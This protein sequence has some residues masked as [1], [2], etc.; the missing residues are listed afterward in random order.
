MITAIKNSNYLVFGILLAGSI[1]ACTSQYDKK[2]EIKITAKEQNVIPDV[3]TIIYAS[4]DYPLSLPGELA[5]Y[6]EVELH[7]KINGFLEKI[8]VQRGDL[9]QKGQ[10]LAELVAPEVDQQYLSDQSVQAEKES[11]YLFAKQAYERL[12]EASKTEGAVAQIELDRANSYMMS[13]KSA[14]ESSQAGTEQSS[15]LKKYLKITA[16][17]EGIITQRN[18]SLG[19]LV[20]PGYKASIF[21]IAQAD[22]LRLTVAIPEKHVAAISEDLKASFMVSSLP[23]KNFEAYLSRSSGILNQQ[24]RSITLEFD[25]ENS[26]GVLRGGEYAQVR[27]NLHRNDSSYWVSPRSIVNAQSGTFI[28]TLREDLIKRVPIKEGIRLDSLVEIFG[29]VQLGDL[30]LTNPSEEIKEG[31]INK[32]K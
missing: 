14:F 22:K 30:V 24:N 9:V 13:A 16:P 28:M 11:D 17:F 2:E 4:Q 32:L 21:T 3:E 29:N 26:K 31:K 23:G 19:A 6:E 25:V 18:L 5:P 27:L 1:S 8:Y 20:G 10:L 12:T 7:A 15:Q